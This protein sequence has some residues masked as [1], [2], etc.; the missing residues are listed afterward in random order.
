MHTNRPFTSRHTHVDNYIWKNREPPR[1]NIIM[2]KWCQTESAD[3]SNIL[4]INY[5]K[6]ASAW[7]NIIIMK[8]TRQHSRSLDKTLFSFD[9]KVQT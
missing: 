6:Y 1:T 7:K 3:I 2:H 9:I 5:R 8:K 4:T